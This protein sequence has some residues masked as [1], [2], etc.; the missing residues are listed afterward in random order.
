MIKQE[1]NKTLQYQ[2]IDTPIGI[3]RLLGDESGLQRLH[4]PNVVDKLEKAIDVREKAK[5][6]LF[7]EAEKWLRDYSEGNFV[8][9]SGGLPGG[10]TDFQRD[11]YLALL[12]V[13]AGE[14]I[15]YSTLAAEAGHPG[16]AR[17]VGRAM[18]TNPLPILVPCHR[19][20]GADGSLTG[21]GGGIE[22]KVKLLQ[23]E[24]YQPK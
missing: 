3:V 2:D 9:W 18:A 24:G 4:L 6:L 8:E 22:A 12:K 10:V 23:H 20:I 16:S 5:P 1:P 14:V 17:A 15:T 11:V 7:V 19:V 21:Y 13:P